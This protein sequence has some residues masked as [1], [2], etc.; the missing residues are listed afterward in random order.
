MAFHPL[1][2]NV[3]RGESP[4]LK[5]LKSYVSFRLNSTAIVL[6]QQLVEIAA[7][8]DMHQHL[9]PKQSGLLDVL[10]KATAK[11]VK[12]V[13][14]LTENINTNSPKKPV[15]IYL[16]H[17]GK[18]NGE[19]CSRLAVTNFPI[20][21]EEDSPDNTVYGTKFSSRKDFN[22][23]FSLMEYVFPKCRE[24]E[25]YNYGSRNME[26]PYFDALM[27]AFIKVAKQ[28]NKVT[29]LFR[30]HLDNPDDMLIDVKWEDKL[31]DLSEYRGLIPG[32]EGNDGELSVA[33]KEA[34]QHAEQ[35]ATP[36][37]APEAPSP[38]AAPAPTQQPPWDT[39]T[40][41]PPPQPQTQAPTQTSTGEEETVAWGDIV[42]NRSTQAQPPQ[43]PA[44]GQQQQ[45]NP[46]A[47]QQQPAWGQPQQQLPPAG[48][49][50]T[51][52]Q[53]P[54]PQ[55]QA[56]QQAP[57]DSYASHPRQNPQQAQMP[58]GGQQGPA[59]MQS[60]TAPSRM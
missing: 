23:F 60:P 28:L 12:A 14:K 20:M 31:D 3:Y 24:L 10:P 21:E 35:H 26:A 5:K 54:N 45:P 39:Q 52:Y 7:N 49:A 11:T 41:T 27:H 30:K 51:Q 29:R 6:L 43:Q 18:Y 47:Q 44:W 4:V 17:G 19:D 50:G 2:E 8:K 33:D 36:T 25:V 15:N 37:P 53:P 59:W 1:G 32:L 48:F 34:A 58:W 56:Y 40:T 46:W 57:A 9:T 13:E 42:K 16:K 22:A 38:F 55:M